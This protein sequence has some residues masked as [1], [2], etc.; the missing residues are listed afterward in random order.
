MIITMG[1]KN[2]DALKIGDGV[3]GGFSKFGGRT[4]DE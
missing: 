2:D 3:R 1:P 4:F